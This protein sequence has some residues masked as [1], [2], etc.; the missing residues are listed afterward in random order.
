MKRIVIAAC[1]FVLLACTNSPPAKP[2][3]DTTE[4]GPLIARFTAVIWPS[5]V[6]NRGHG[7]GDPQSANPRKV[8]FWSVVDP[9]ADANLQDE[10]K[11]LGTTT[12]PDGAILTGPGD[13]IKLV[14]ASVTSHDGSLASV[15]ACYTYTSKTNADLASKGPGSPMASEV[16]FTLHKTDDWLVQSIS[17]DHVVPSCQSNK[18]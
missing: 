10:A 17:N 8:K 3:P 12:A 11:A 4:G 1:A 14:N 16:T 18:A 6:D 9:G 7:Q 13:S 2:V 5:I 15:A